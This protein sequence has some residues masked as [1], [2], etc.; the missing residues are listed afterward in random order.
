MVLSLYPDPIKNV[1][2]KLEL[3]EA[4]YEAL[5]VR[6]MCEKT[7]LVHL[8]QENVETIRTNVRSK[9]VSA[10]APPPGSPNKML[11]HISKQI[12]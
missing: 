9:S 4:T 2:R 8:V 10:G 3:M 5:S 6:M 11:G 1:K 12:V 7:E